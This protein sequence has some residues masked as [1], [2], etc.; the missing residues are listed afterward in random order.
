M[1]WTLCLNDGGSVAGA[2]PLAD[3]GLPVLSDGKG[4]SVCWKEEAGALWLMVDARSHP[5]E[6]VNGL[7]RL[8]NPSQGKLIR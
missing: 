3:G 6:Q 2:R 4:D 5:I 1:V 8:R 7:T